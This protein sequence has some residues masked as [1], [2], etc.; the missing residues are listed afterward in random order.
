MGVD[1]TRAVVLPK[2]T[3]VRTQKHEI[4][5]HRFLMAFLGAIERKGYTVGTFADAIGV[6]RRHMS[7]VINGK[8]EL[9]AVKWRAALRALG[10]KQAY[11]EAAIKVFE[12]V[13]R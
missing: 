7:R 5:K 13:G 12:S 8:G 11:L 1:K 2:H 10:V 4:V 9:S 6:G 3:S